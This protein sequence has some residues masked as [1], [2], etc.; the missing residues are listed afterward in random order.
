[1]PYV[2]L[3]IVHT[4]GKTPK[5][6]GDVSHLII[7]DRS[8]CSD[9]LMMELAQEFCRKHNRL[10]VDCSRRTVRRKD[11]PESKGWGPQ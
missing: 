5:F 6:P 1:M 8:T 11:V 4:D 9:M 3:N 2:R 7:E 10:L